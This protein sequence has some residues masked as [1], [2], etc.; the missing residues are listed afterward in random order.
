M[1]LEL[2]DIG[3]YR[4]QVTLDRVR[5][6]RWCNR[7]ILHGLEYYGQAVETTNSD[8]LISKVASGDIAAMLALLYGAASAE[9]PGITPATYTRMVQPERGPEYVDVVLDGLRHYLPPPQVQDDGQN[10]DEDWPDTQAEVRKRGPVQCTDWGQWYRFARTEYGMTREE[11]LDTT[12]RELHGLDM[13]RL[14]DR[15]V[16]IWDKGVI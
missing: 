8:T 2:Q 16:V 1:N 5:W 13:Q 10:L 7:A 4:N 3:P 12:Q 15:G 6:L 11:F 9:D 14:V